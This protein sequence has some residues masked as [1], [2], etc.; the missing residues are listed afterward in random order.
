MA[1]LDE[2]LRLIDSKGRRVYVT[3]K[4]IDLRNLSE[5]NTVFILQLPDGST[6]A[7]GRGGGLGERRI[8]KMYHF[9]YGNG[10][11]HELP[12]V[13]DDDRLDNLDLPYHA[14]AMAV[15]LQD[16]KEKLVSGVVDPEFVSSYRQATVG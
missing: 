13:E 6:A 3:E 14:T 7:G 16:G 8:V 5:T 12:G 10:E 2:F 15:I 4:P 9:Q 1:G 11:C